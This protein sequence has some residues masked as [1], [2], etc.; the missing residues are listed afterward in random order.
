MY[1][2]SYWELMGDC[3]E[4]MDMLR[5][6]SKAP[7]LLE[8]PPLELP[9]PPALPRWEDFKP[10]LHVIPQQPTLPPLKLPPF[11]APILET[12]VPF[13]E[14][15][16]LHVPSVPQAPKVRRGTTQPRMVL[17][18]LGVTSHVTAIGS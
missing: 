11:R 14:P 7:A 8:E 13:L 5:K 10:E 2:G 15:E 6:M 16:Y 3:D 12:D 1:E 4:L 17:R 18:S 9:P